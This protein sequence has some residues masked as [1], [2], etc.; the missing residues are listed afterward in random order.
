V[1]SLHFSSLESD[2]NDYLAYWCLTP[3]WTEL[4]NRNPIEGGKETVVSQGG[5]PEGRVYLKVL[6]KCCATK[7]PVATM[8]LCSCFPDFIIDLLKYSIC[9]GKSVVVAFPT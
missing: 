1:R 4:A 9:S 5:V 2:V 8:K 7:L 6:R 3:C